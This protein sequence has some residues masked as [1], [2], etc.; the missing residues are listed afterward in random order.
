MA[1]ASLFVAACF[2]TFQGNLEFFAPAAPHDGAPPASW[3]PVVPNPN[4]PFVYNPCIYAIFPTLPLECGGGEVAA[5]IEAMD[6]VVRALEAIRPKY[7][8]RLAEV[9]PRGDVTFVEGWSGDALVDQIN[10]DLSRYG[11]R[12][13]EYEEV[14]RRRSGHRIVRALCKIGPLY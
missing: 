1:P 14:I 5:M 13:V 7:G 12:I 4:C 10:R 8:F 11:Y 6:E 3:A 9:G 2:G